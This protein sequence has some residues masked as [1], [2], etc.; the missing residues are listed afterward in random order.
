MLEK[1]TAVG[2]TQQE[3][4][5]AKLAAKRAN[6][7]AKAS[8]ERA[9][10]CAAAY[11]ALLRLEADERGGPAGPPQEAQAPAQDWLCAL[12]AQPHGLRAATAGIA[13]R[14]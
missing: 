11:R 8:T 4:R 2:L 12:R 14:G 1:R 7:A 3:T 9:H 10:R 5:K 6:R 13:S